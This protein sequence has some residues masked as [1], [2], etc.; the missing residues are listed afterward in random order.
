M[1]FAYSGSGAVPIIPYFSQM[2]VMD[3]LIENTT[4]PLFINCSRQL[5]TSTI[6][7]AYALHQALSDQRHNVLILTTRMN[8]AYEFINRARFMIGGHLM[9]VTGAGNFIQNGTKTSLTMF[10][11]SRIEAMSLSDRVRGSRADTLIIDGLY[12]DPEYERRC[13]GDVVQPLFARAKRVVVASTPLVK[14][15]LFQYLW[16]NHPTAD[17][18]TLKW[19]DHP[20]RDDAWCQQVKLGMSPQRWATEFEGQF[21]VSNPHI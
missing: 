11:G 14:E 5:G 2:Q 16:F 7:A 10:N 6:L 17:R 20:D 13:Y 1:C 21:L 9:S 12:N 3:K 15:G 19:S 4:N 18:I 8:E